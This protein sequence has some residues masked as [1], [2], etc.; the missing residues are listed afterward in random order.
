MFDDVRFGNGPNHAFYSVDSNEGAWNTGRE[1]YPN[2]GYKPRHK[3]GYFPAPPTDQ[4][5]DLRHEM[6]EVMESVG[7]T[8][9]REHHEVATGGQAEIDFKFAPLTECGD[10]TMWLKYVIKNV[11]FL[12]GQT[13]TFMPKPIAGDN[14]SGMHCHQSLWKDGKPLFAG[15]DYGGLSARWPFTTSAAS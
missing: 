4:M 15:D 2:Q 7:L 5:T 10:M 12:N 9:E 13:A 1:E 8:I 14:G 11:A 6:V 3:G